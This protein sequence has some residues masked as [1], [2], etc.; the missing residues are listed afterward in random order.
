MTKKEAN[1]GEDTE[2]LVV[3]ASAVQEDEDDD[4]AAH[5]PGWAAAERFASAASEWAQLPLGNSTLPVV[6]RWDPWSARAKFETNRSGVLHL[7]ARFRPR[8]RRTVLAYL[9]GGMS[10]KA[11]ASEDG[12]TVFPCIETD[13]MDSKEVA[14]RHKLCSRARRHVQ[15]AHDRLL[16]TRDEGLLLPDDK[17]LA[18]FEAHPELAALP[19]EAGGV[20]PVDWQWTAD[21]DAV[22][23]EKSN[24]RADPLYALA[25]AMC[26]GKAPGLVIEPVA[27]AAVLF[28]V[29]T[30][31]RRGTLEPDWH[32]W[33]AG[34]RPKS[35]RGHRWTAQLFFEA[36]AA[37]GGDS[38]QHV[39]SSQC[40]DDGSDVRS[41]PSNPSEKN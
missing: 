4:E 12:F 5:G 13:D 21:H 33:H 3:N 17:Q 38:A 1:G 23:E 11:T 41:C 7:D 26:H 27:G 40:A 22:A 39:P 6:S 9:S 24:A 2:V 29:S 16:Q 34:C 19:K 31:G 10:G 32:L 37:I 14:R 15:H 35:G 25:E 36:P 28:E 8:S 30:A 18:F 20:R